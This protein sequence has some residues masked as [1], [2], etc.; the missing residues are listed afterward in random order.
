MNRLAVSAAV[1]QAERY[2]R[3]VLWL[4]DLELYLG[5]DGLTR[6]L[7]VRLLNS[8]GHHAIVSTMRAAEHA[9]YTD[10]AAYSEADQ[11]ARELTRDARD[12]IE[13]AHLIMSPEYLLDSNACGLMLDAGTPA[14]Q[15]L[16]HMLIDTASR[17]P[18]RPALN[19]WTSGAMRGNQVAT[20]VALPLSP[21]RL[22]AVVLGLR[23]PFRA[24]LSSNSTRIICLPEVVSACDRRP[25]RRRG[26]G[27]PTRAAPPLPS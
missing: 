3:W 11:A 5:A 15:T 12:V 13:Q 9:R 10:P 21:P 2:E 25:L 19:C 23:A 26:L 7:L 14:S 22:T 1:G 18:G 24:A 8:P 6:A 16:S 20:H 17:I 27:R 4:D